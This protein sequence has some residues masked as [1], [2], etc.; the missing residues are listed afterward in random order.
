MERKK[1]KK[2]MGIAG[3]ILL[4]LNLALFSFRIYSDIV[5]WIVLGVVAIASYLL[6]KAFK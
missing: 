2:A 6:L 4:G 1:I 5:F 3:I